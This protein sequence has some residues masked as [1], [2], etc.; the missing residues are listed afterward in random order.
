MTKLTSAQRSYLTKR[1]HKIRP[2]V[3][4][5]QKGLTDAIGNATLEAFKHNEIVKVKFSSNRELKRDISTELESFTESFLVR[6]I[7]HIAI[8][9]KPFEEKSDRVLHLPKK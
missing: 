2:V 3:Y 1:S 9:Y 5:G 8:Y 7:G 6:I 4:V